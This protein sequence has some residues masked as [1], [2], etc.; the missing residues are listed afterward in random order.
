MNVMALGIACI[1]TLIVIAGFYVARKI[2]NKFGSG[3]IQILSLVLGFLAL[4]AF[5]LDNE[6][7]SQAGIYWFIML[8]IFV[9]IGKVLGKKTNA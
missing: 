1:G 9:I 8:I 4:V 3:A 5:P 2:Q 7:A 6:S